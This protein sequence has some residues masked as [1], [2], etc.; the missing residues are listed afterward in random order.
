MGTTI[1]VVDD[2][3][4]FQPVLVDELNRAGYEGLG[5]SS[6]EEALK[7]CEAETVHVAVIDI[8]MPNMSGMQ[9]IRSLRGT[10]PDMKIMA[11]TGEQ[12]FEHDALEAFGADKALHKPFRGKQFLDAVEELLQAGE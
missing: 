12:L 4:E 7:I 11:I 6:G 5:A 9:T 8:F 10:Y 3:E 1:L 2:D